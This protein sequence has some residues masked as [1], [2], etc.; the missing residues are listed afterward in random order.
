MN[1][2]TLTAA[3][4]LT[5]VALAGCS[6]SKTTTPAAAPPAAGG[7]APTPT[8]AAPAAAPA[9]D[10]KTVTAALTKAI[11]TVKL[12]VTYDATSDPNTRLGRP[13]QYVSKT[14][15]DDTRV[16]SLPKAAEDATDNRRD[17]ISYGG[18]VEVFAN[19]AD[20][21]AWATY[22]DKAQQALGGLATP[23]Y[24][25]QHGAVVVRVSHLLT[26]AQAA[27][28]QKALS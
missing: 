19:D 27:E 14:A 6:S 23:D 25:Y 7:A 24:I 13:H 26:A 1:R 15:F 22:V 20:A 21:T 28:Y 4:V 3:A 9:G 2:A 16:S 12:T 17:S 5:A 11:P 18:T 8:A 10:A